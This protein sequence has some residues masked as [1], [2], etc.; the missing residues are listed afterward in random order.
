[1]KTDS[2]NGRKAVLVDGCRIPFLRSGTGYQDLSSYDLGR[3]ALK[4]LLER[5]QIP[6][7]KIDQIIMGT[8]ISNMATSNVARESALGAGIPPGV[9]ASTV[10][11][12]CISANLAITNGVNLIRT[13]QADIIVAGGTES[14]SDVPIRYRKQFRKKLMETQ[15][16]KHFLD[17]RKFFKGL[18]LSDFLPEIPAVAEFATGRTM[19]Q[20]CDRLAARLGVTR[21]E[22]DAFA[23]RSH[24][25]A[26]KASREGLFDQ[27]IEPVRVPPDFNPIDRDNGIRADT[28]LEKMQSL[29]PAFVKPFG[30]VT[31]GNSSFLSDGAAA[32]LI[33]AENV[34]VAMNFKPKAVIH[35]FA[36][37][38]QD[39]LE[40]LLL[41]PAY[42]VPRV[43]DL[44]GLT[45]SDID[46]F[47][48]H[49]AFA[50]QVLAN[51]K[52]L[53]SDQFARQ[54]LGKDKKIGEISM[55]KLNI[56]GGSLSLGHP[57]GA[58]GARLV[59]TAANRL[60]REDGQFALIASCAGGAHGN[61][62]I[63]ER[64]RNT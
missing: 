30:T 11:L 32:V 44:A 38:A 26:G 17:Y 56:L 51:L 25:Q 62:I 8:V 3:L 13:L 9:P 21:Q 58:T 42:A 27:E 2:S 49:E 35:S 52:C 22:Q 28:S 41:G 45:L 43:L 59:T 34:A 18:S 63:L 46:V 23:I 54:Q 57:F 12:A 47:E 36:Y 6:A 60:N 61:A 15:K 50:G 64:Y 40:E 1:M 16:Y 5:T 10:T 55:D 20:D 24:Q 4:A 31:A 39:P 14:L 29:A 7:D 33:M 53:D 19:G 37:T 48:F